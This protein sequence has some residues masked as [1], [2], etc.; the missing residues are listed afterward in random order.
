MVSVIMTTSQTECRL[1][2]T[3]MGASTI[4]PLIVRL[5]KDPLLF[6]YT[7]Y[8][9][10]KQDPFSSS[11]HFSHVVEIILYGFVVVPRIH[12]LTS[13]HVQNVLFC[14]RQHTKQ[15]H[16]SDV[17]TRKYLPLSVSINTCY[18]LG[19]CLPSFYPPDVHTPPKSQP[20]RNMFSFILHLASY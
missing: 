17:K 18:V 9:I 8:D 12:S 7:F 5:G 4:C 20:S 6:T 3:N 2:Y 11:L 14:G 10:R 19:S 1:V 13:D 16:N 15:K